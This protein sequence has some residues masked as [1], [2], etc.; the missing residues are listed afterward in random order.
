MAFAHYVENQH[1]ST[2]FYAFNYSKSIGKHGTTSHI[3]RKQDNKKNKRQ[4]SSFLDEINIFSLMDKDCSSKGIQ[5]VVSRN[6]QHLY[7]VQCFIPLS[8]LHKID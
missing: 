2:G 5:K 3:V 4:I 1:I 6:R 8:I 7:R